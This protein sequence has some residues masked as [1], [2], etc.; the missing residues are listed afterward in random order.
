MRA[1][2]FDLGQ[3]LENEGEL[4]PGA[5]EMLQ[6]VQVMRDSNN[7]T[8]ILAL[9][10][11]YYDAKGPAEIKRFREEYYQFL[12]RIGVGHFFRPPSERVTLTME[13]GAKT[14]DENV[15][16]A[17]MDK[18][19]KDLPFHHAIFVTGDQEHLEPVINFK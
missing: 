15:F 14:P 12:E 8:P 10:S 17:A 6:A 3:T 5:L 16:R 7:K 13:V 2:F 11:D 18:I 19:Q 4:L 1:I 9:I